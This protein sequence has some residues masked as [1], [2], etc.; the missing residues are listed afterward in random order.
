MEEK[1]QEPVDRDRHREEEL[2]Q[3]REREYWLRNRL[4][5]EREENLLIL[6]YLS[7]QQETA[8][9]RFWRWLIDDTRSQRRQERA[10]FAEYPGQ[11]PE[12]KGFR[13]SRTGRFMARIPM[14]WRRDGRR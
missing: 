12:V 5:R 7:F 11:L 10:L 14:I 13:N 1:Q 9:M 3:A 4:D 8:P 2:R 6:R